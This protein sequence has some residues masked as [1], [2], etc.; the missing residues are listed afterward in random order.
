MVTAQ[1]STEGG[2]VYVMP[3]DLQEGD[4]IPMSWEEYEALP[5]TVRGEY[6]DGA[7][8]VSP[9]PTGRHQD[10]SL[11]LPLLL[12]NVLPNQTRV[13]LAWAWKPGA[14]EFIPDVIVF[15]ETEEDKRLTVLPHLAVEVLSTDKAADT[16]RK[17]H[18]YATAGLRNYWIIDPD[19]PEVIVYRLGD[20]GTYI[21]TGRHSAGETT[22]FDFGIATVRFDPADLLA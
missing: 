17:F 9:S 12:R 1:K 7:L 14:D 21:E 10:I 16:L 20:D 15:D 5:D 2:T 19:G 6:I 4:R 18:K 13:R 11:N 8:V 3:T 22:E